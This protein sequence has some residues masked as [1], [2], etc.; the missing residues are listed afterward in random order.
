MDGG[1]ITDTVEHESKTCRNHATVSYIFSNNRDNEPKGGLSQEGRATLLGH[2]SGCQKC[3]SLSFCDDLFNA[4]GIFICQT[5]RKNEKLISKVR[6]I[7]CW[8]YGWGLE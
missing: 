4:F 2:S 8:D 3:S 6:T 7:F 1:F 5:C